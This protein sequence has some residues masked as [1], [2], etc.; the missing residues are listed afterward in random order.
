MQPTVPWDSKCDI[1]LDHCLKELP[2]QTG[3]AAAEAEV[4]AET[5]TTAEVKP[6]EHETAGSDSQQHQQLLQPDKWLA[7]GVN[8]L[9][10]LGTAQ[11][12]VW[13]VNQHR[14]AN[15]EAVKEWQAIGNCFTTQK[16]TRRLWGG[17]V[18]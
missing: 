10:E 13:D 17:G 12:T 4:T 1:P 18:S 2:V 9:P 8:S 14:G 3:S 5:E 15:A 16:V 6:V 11:V 7:G